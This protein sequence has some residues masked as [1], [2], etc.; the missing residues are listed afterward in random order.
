VEV[1]FM[2]KVPIPFVTFLGV[3]LL[4]LRLTLPLP[5]V[6]DFDLEGVVIFQ[7]Q[8]VAHAC[9]CQKNGAPTHGTCEAADFVHIHKGRYG[10]IP[11]DG[12]NAVTIGNLVDKNQ[13]RLYST[14]YID[15]TANPTQRQALSA[16]EQFLNG[17]YESS[18]LQASPV[19][20]VSMTFN[21]SPDK[22]TYN[23]TVPEILEERTLLQRDSSGKPVSTEIAMDAWANLEH[24]ADNIKFE[25]HDKKVHRNWDHSGAYANIKYFH[26]TKGMYDRREM[27]EQYGDFSGHWTPEQLDLIHK[28]G[29]PEK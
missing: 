13:G 10:N 8:C 29:L 15:Q 4:P 22:T 23:I 9:P 14:I 26:L 16:I 19:R 7:C 6:K 21:E 25:Y 2:R 28:Q 17:A 11:L 5:T 3:C 18:P 12:L 20:F 1:I 27:L 24:Y